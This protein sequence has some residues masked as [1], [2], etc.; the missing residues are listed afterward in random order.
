MQCRSRHYSQPEDIV[1]LEEVIEIQAAVIDMCEKAR[2]WKAKPL[3]QRP[4]MRAVANKILPSLRHLKERCF[5]LELERRQTCILRKEQQRAIE[6][7]HI[8][9]QER[10]ERETR[11]IKQHIQDNLREFQLAPRPRKTTRQARQNASPRVV[12]ERQILGSLDLGFGNSDNV[13]SWTPQDR[14]M[15]GRPR[16][17]GLQSQQTVYPVGPH[18]RRGATTIDPWTKDQNMA[19]VEQLQNPASRYLPGKSTL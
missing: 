14:Q 18:Q 15:E 19:L 3:T 5:D 13:D 11:E 1:N 10:Q 17:V 6:K 4:I 12:R 16:G 8:M 9:W 2:Q 7:A